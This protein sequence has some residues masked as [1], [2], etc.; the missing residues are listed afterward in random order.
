[1]VSRDEAIDDTDDDDDGAHDL[2][3]TTMLML[4]SEWYVFVR[5]AVPSFVHR[6][7]ES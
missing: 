7:E 2:V 4:P 3:Y 5:T 6:F 1:M